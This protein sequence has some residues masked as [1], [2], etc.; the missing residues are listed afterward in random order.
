[1]T[2]LDSQVSLEN[3]NA[4]ICDTAIHF[5]KLEKIYVDFI[6]V[7]F[8]QIYEDKVDNNLFPPLQTQMIR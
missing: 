2:S 7:F 8:A 4:A 5:F 6:S 3:I 1:M